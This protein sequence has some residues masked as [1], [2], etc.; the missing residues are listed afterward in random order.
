MLAAARLLTLLALVWFAPGAARAFWLAL[1]RLAGLPTWPHL[2]V[3]FI[4][5]L[6]VGRFALDKLPTLC[7]AEHELTH[8]IA[9]L[10]FLCRPTRLVVSRHGGVAGHRDTPLP[11]IGPLVDDFVTLAPY[12]LPT[13]SLLIALAAPLA[14]LSAKFTVHLAI[15][16]TLGYHLSTTAAELWVNWTARR[17][18]RADNGQPIRSDIAQVGFVLS[19]VYI[20]VM[21]LLLHGLT[22]ALTADGYAGVPA[23]GAEIVR[24]AG[25]FWLAY[26]R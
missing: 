26:L 10:P 1:G 22:F 21:A 19:L 18:S 23:W 12:V 7:I 14:P 4:A 24:T 8:L 3:G 20:P 25:R 16:L 17:V 13:F 5:G 2:L 9:G 6:A 15:G 11:W